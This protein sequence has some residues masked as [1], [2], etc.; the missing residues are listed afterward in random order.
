MQTDIRQAQVSQGG[1]GSPA[2]A[3]GRERGQEQTLPR[4]SSESQPCCRPDLRRL[5]SRAVR[6]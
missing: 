3:G 2:S 1:P 4:P 6:Q 5:V